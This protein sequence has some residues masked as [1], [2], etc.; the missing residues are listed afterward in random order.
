MSFEIFAKLVN[1]RF[2]AL[3]KHELFV[4]GNDNRIHRTKVWEVR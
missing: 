1:A 4:V 3:S 2:A